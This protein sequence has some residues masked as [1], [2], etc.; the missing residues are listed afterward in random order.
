MRVYSRYEYPRITVS[1][2]ISINLHG[3][4]VNH[5]SIA[6]LVDHKTTRH[7]LICFKYL[8]AY[9]TLLKELLDKYG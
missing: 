7:L 9:L 4:S 5:I 8:P 1:V 3:L 2:N 6:V